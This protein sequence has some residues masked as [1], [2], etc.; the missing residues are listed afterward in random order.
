MG[1]GDQLRTTAMSVDQ[2]EALALSLEEERQRL[3]E[4][5]NSQADVIQAQSERVL[6]LEEELANCLGQTPDDPADQPLGVF[7][8][9][10]DEDSATIVW[11]DV[12]DED[13]YTV[14]LSEDGL[15]WTVVGEAPRDSAALELS[16]LRADSP[17]LVRVTAF[18]S[19]G[20]EG[21]SE[22]FN[23][24]TASEPTLPPPT[25]TWV[26]PTGPVSIEWTPPTP[27]ITLSPGE[28]VRAAYNAGHRKIK[29]LPG[30]YGNQVLGSMP[31]AIIWCV[32]YAGAHFDGN[33]GAGPFITPGDN[34]VYVNLWFERYNLHDSG[35]SGSMVN[36]TG[37]N[38]MRFLNCKAGRSKN[39]AYLL[40]GTDGELAGGEVYQISRYVWAGSGVNWVHDLWIEEIRTGVGVAKSTSSNSGVCKIVFSRRWRIQRI[41]G[42]NVGWNVIWFDIQNEPSLIEDIFIDGVAKSIVFL[43]VSFGGDQSSGQWETWRV[44]NVGGVQKGYVPSA[45]ESPSWP[46]PFAFGSSAVPDIRANGIYGRGFRSGVALFND[47]NHPQIL[48]EKKDENG[49]WRPFGTAYKQRNRMGIQNIVVE[50]QDTPDSI[51]FLCSIF[52]SGHKK[53]YDILPSL[54]LKQPTGLGWK[55]LTSRSGDNFRAYNDELDSVVMS[56]A[57]FRSRYVSA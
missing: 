45:S 29:L 5:T 44:N 20:T 21:P 48:G 36:A 35:E 4:L 16:N 18:N 34:V 38:G 9:N 19:D 15:M 54:K 24:R 7:A 32:T 12:A 43:E 33:F 14:E 26:P 2:V 56:E 27:D 47:P 37:S 17:Y 51:D 11:G 22:P 50:N 3:Q 1:L 52:G 6:I 23:F 49:I 31:N 42:R 40:K 41:A 46:V 28:S 57:Q 25:G 53:T 8:E 39:N 10:V 30:N 13:H 55:K